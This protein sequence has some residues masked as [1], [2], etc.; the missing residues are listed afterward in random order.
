MFNL[1][2]LILLQLFPGLVDWVLRLNAASTAV[3][4]ELGPAETAKALSAIAAILIL[5]LGGV[6]I[7]AMTGRLMRRSVLKNKTV[8]V[9]SST[10]ADFGK[11]DWARPASEKESTTPGKSPEERQ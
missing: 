2:N 1:F 8:P 5:G 4:K 7:I 9:A 10:D 6:L 11:V 3:T